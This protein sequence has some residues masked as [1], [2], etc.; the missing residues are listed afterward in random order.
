MV[1]STFSNP[2]ATGKL[3]D[4]HPPLILRKMASV[5]EVSRY[6]T[7]FDLYLP[8]V[9]EDEDFW[10]GTVT[11]EW[12][13]WLEPGMMNIR[14]KA[15]KVEGTIKITERA[16]SQNH[17]LYARFMSDPLDNLGP[18]T[19]ATDEVY[20]TVYPYTRNEIDIWT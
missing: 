18:Y 9:M 16:V 3:N 15:T 2:V 11:G 8:W 4:S 7:W 17:A 6:D 10:Y 19:H 12:L 5:L 1:M 14:H 20:T 13:R